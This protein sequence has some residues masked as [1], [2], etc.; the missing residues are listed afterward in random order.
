MSNNSHQKLQQQPQEILLKELNEFKDTRYGNVTLYINPDSEMYY[1]RKDKV[2]QSKKQVSHVVR[3]INKRINHPNLYYVGPLTYEYSEIDSKS[4]ANRKLPVLRLYMPYPEENLEDELKKR[5]TESRPFDNREMTYM[6]YDLLQGFYHLQTLGFAHNRFGPEFVATTTTGFAILDDPMHYPFDVVNLKRRKEWYLSPEAYR[7]ALLKQKAG[8]DY[9]LI[10]SDVFSFG[11]VLLEAGLQMNVNEIYGQP[12]ELKLDEDTLE[13]LI[14]ML[15]SRY[16]DNNLVVSTV[17]KML[18]IDPEMRPDFKEMISQLPPYE[19]IQS[20]F[21][22]SHQMTEKERQSMRESIHGQSQGRARRVHDVQEFARKRPETEGQRMKA[23]PSIKRSTYIE[24]MENFAQNQPQPQTGQGQQPVGAHG[25]KNMIQSEVVEKEVGGQSH[26]AVGGHG[27]APVPQN[28]FHHQVLQPQN[29]TYQNQVATPGAEVGH[30]IPGKPL[31]RVNGGIGKP[32]T[33]KKVMKQQPEPAAPVGAPLLAAEIP[34]GKNIQ[35]EAESPQASYPVVETQ[36]Q[37]QSTPNQQLNPPQQPPT[38]QPQQPQPQ[39]QEQPT[40]HQEAPQTQ[41]VLPSIDIEALVRLKVMEELK[42]FEAARKKEQEEKDRI[43]KERRDQERLERDME[44]ENRIKQ[45]EFQKEMLEKENEENKKK[46]AEQQRLADEVQAKL[47]MEQEAQIQLKALQEAEMEKRLA[48]EAHMHAK[49]LE[50]E[51]AR[52]EEILKKNELERLE[53]KGRLEKE[54]E[55]RLEKQKEEFLRQKKEREEAMRKQREEERE[56]ALRQQK[57]KEEALRQKQLM[58]EALKE[59][60]LKEEEALRQQ[61]L[62]EEEALRQQRLREEELKKKALNSARS[63]SKS[64]SLM[65]LTPLA[66]AC[67]T[68]HSARL[69]NHSVNLPESLENGEKGIGCQEPR[70]SSQLSR[71]TEATANQSSSGQTEVIDVKF[72]EIRQPKR[73]RGRKPKPPLYYAIDESEIEELPAV[74]STQLNSTNKS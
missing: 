33:P 48:E 7:A 22:K 12:G 8:K 57:E 74:S 39:A 58:E 10:K 47:K 35:I 5:I 45:L 71:R 61:K 18:T 23:S 43:E 21:E 62:R 16:P 11:L 30:M 69:K 32:P 14:Q 17:R 53:E 34:L 59:Q 70:L 51:R 15:K 2:F 63:P 20:Y 26:P 13:G 52:H 3:E 66:D 42:K 31:S 24:E 44:I 27:G 60:K 49:R 65:D 36:N 28:Q 29:Q 6:M 55:E 4:Q 38:Q 41:P 73:P 50:E 54:A 1:T 56:E 67:P 72:E 68:E 46:I 64:K 19:M 40:M 9:D 25:A 37:P